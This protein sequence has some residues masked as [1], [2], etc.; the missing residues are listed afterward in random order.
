MGQFGGADRTPVL[1]PD[2]GEQE[3]Q[4]CQ[5]DP[6][7]ARPPNSPLPTMGLQFVGVRSGTAPDLKRA[8]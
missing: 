7:H 4:A 5:R 3:A 1:S 2:L 8:L 6:R